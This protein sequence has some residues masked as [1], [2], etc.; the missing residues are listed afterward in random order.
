MKRRLAMLP[1]RPVKA[2][3]I[4][5]YSIALLMAIVPPFYLSASGNATLIAGMPAAIL[6]W[7]V[8]AVLVAFALT[9]LYVYEDARGELDEE[10]AP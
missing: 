7:I 1:P 3:L 9:A 8:N 10:I 5:I 6:Y 2:I 4:G